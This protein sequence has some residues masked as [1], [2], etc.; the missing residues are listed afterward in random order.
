MEP[1]PAFSIPA[2]D[3]TTDLSQLDCSTMAM[4]LLTCDSVTFVMQ[5]KDEQGNFKTENFSELRH[6][7]F[8]IK[9]QDGN[10][11]GEKPAPARSASLSWSFESATLAVNSSPRR[12]LACAKQYTLEESKLEFT[13]LSMWESL[14]LREGHKNSAHSS[15]RCSHDCFRCL[16]SG[17]LLVGRHGCCYKD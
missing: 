11:D 1:Q 8:G 5:I 13:M 4:L 17:V 16:L 12:P 2:H 6:V 15:P 3:A 7:A 14:T 9:D 10:A